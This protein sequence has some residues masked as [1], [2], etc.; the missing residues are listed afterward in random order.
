[1]CFSIFKSLATL[2][3]V[4]GLWFNSGG[5]Q[6]KGYGDGDCYELIETV[7]GSSIVPWQPV[8]EYDLTEE[9]SE[10]GKPIVERLPASAAH[11]G[12]LSVFPELYTLY[13]VND[14][15]RCE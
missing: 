8:V 7:V 5:W 15:N 13:L 11:A 4:E 10:A 6:V 12:P 3:V 14:L 1:M 9:S 2:I